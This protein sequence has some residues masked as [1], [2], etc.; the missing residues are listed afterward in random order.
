MMKFKWWNLISP[1]LFWFY[2]VFSY[3]KSLKLG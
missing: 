2:N 3:E 1:L